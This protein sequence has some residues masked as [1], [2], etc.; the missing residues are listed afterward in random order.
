MLTDY[1]SFQSVHVSWQQNDA[2]YLY[3]LANLFYWLSVALFLKALPSKRFFTEDKETRLLIGILIPILMNVL[4]NWNFSRK[5]LRN[6]VLSIDY[7]FSVAFKNRTI[8]QFKK[9]HLKKKK[10]R[11][12][13]INF[14]FFSKKIIIF[15][16]LE[17]SQC[18]NFLHILYF[19]QYGFGIDMYTCNVQFYNG[20]HFHLIGYSISSD[21]KT[22]L[23]LC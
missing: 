7:F 15:Q 1:S 10:T 3:V 12:I 2:Q 6:Y 21:T 23:M 22:Q 11:S 18:F 5:Q 13:C 4:L 14:F 9:L 20:N 17:K 16:I 19:L 8:L